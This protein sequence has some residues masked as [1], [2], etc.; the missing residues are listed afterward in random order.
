METLVIVTADHETGYL[1][2]PGSDPGWEPLVNHGAGNPPGMEWHSNVHTNSLVPV[3]AKG[4][5]AGYLA[6]YADEQDPVRGAYI[7]NT[8]IAHLVFE[9][10]E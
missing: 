7:D 9:W 3:Y 10:M 5:G 4:A 8:E 2:G 1:T 6:A